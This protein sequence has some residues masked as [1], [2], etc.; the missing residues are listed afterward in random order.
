MIYRLVGH[1]RASPFA[2]YLL[3]GPGVAGTAYA[4]RPAVGRDVPHDH[5]HP[6]DHAK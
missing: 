5:L 3:L 6:G 2:H 4:E 1:T